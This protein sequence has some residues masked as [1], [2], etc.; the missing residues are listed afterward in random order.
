MRVT[1]LEKKRREHAWTKA[2]LARR[3]KMQGST[4]GWIEEGRFKPY[5]SQLKK[6]AEQLEVADPHKLLDISEA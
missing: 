3:A 2:E 5:D 1:I 4:I 6:L